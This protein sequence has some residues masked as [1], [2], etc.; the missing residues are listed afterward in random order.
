MYTREFIYKEIINKTQNYLE[1]SD[2]LEREGSMRLCILGTWHA[3]SMMWFNG[4]SRNR[5]NWE[6]SYISFLGSF[7]SLTN[8]DVSLLRRISEC[9]GGTASWSVDALDDHIKPIQA[10]STELRRLR[11]HRSLETCRKRQI[12]AAYHA[13]AQSL[14]NIFL[15]YILY[16]PR[17]QVGTKRTRGKG[18]LR[19]R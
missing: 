3:H 15:S 14:T 17:E 8:I 16:I 5:V 6:R 19:N 4:G 11:F 13:F 7:V 2:I 10:A 9:I 1:W 18:T 12:K